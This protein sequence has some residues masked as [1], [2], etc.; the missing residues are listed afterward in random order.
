VFAKHSGEEGPALLR[1]DLMRNC[2][3]LS[4]LEFRDLIS[5]GAERLKLIR[6]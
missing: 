6:G 5:R 2:K 3:L 4:G 1:P